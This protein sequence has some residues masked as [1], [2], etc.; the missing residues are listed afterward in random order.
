MENQT[1]ELLFDDAGTFA[2]D[3]ALMKELDEAW[4]DAEGESEAQGQEETDDLEADQPTETV[5][6]AV[7]S[8]QTQAQR[9]AADE[10][11]ET[12]TL[13]HLEEVRTVDR[14]EV[15]RL[16]Q[17]GLDYQ[18]IRTDRDRL[19]ALRGE[20]GPAAQAEA[21]RTEERREDMRRFLR[22]FPTV[23]PEEIPKEVWSQVA[24]GED[25]ATAY[26]FHHSRRLEA[27]LAAE[28]QNHRNAGNTTGSLAGGMKGIPR[29]EFLKW[30]DDEE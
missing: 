6:K 14:D 7:D 25:L 18:R 20:A 3:E 5:P 28:R 11:A 12:F 15:I 30:W 17:Q 13:K 21:V 9:T 19:R 24:A 26:V 2:P 23:K 22:Q 29:D 8:E 16:A 10:R 27:E 1:Q 4:N